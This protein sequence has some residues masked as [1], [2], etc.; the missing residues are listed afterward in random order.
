M[1]KQWISAK[2]PKL[3]GTYTDWLWFLNQFKAETDS[4][5]VAQIF[6]S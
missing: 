6:V 3:Q 4:A 5:D 2:L 1:K